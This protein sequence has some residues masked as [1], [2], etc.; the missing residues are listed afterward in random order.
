MGKGTGRIVLYQRQSAER[1]CKG[2]PEGATYVV[3]PKIKGN[4]EKSQESATDE[5]LAM[6]SN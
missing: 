1:T 4:T 2:R 6:L 3:N 5:I